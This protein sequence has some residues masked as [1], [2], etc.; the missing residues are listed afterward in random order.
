MNTTAVVEPSVEVW[1]G[2]SDNPLAL[3]AAPFV[4]GEYLHRNDETRVLVFSSAP[5][6]FSLRSQSAI[7]PVCKKN[8]SDVEVFVYLLQAGPDAVE[9]FFRRD[10]ADGVA[11]QARR[12][13]SLKN[14]IAN[15]TNRNS[16][17][18]NKIEKYT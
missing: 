18:P 17:N 16:A 5:P 7:F 15:T 13:R 3:R 2:R 11:F 9:V 8:L 10:L 1:Q 12:R 14:T 6:D 4:K